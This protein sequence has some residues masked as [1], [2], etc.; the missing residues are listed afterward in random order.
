M[1]FGRM[2]FGLYQASSDIWQYG[3]DSSALIQ[4]DDHISDSS[5]SDDD[6]PRGEDWH[7]DCEIPSDPENPD[8]DEDFD[9][10]I[11]EDVDSEEDEEAENDYIS[12]CKGADFFL[13]TG[14]WLRLSEALFQLSMMFWTY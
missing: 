14:Y 5:D 8:T 10:S 6:R 11:D 2:A 9:E 1:L 3:K 12:D 4:R 7:D 13:P